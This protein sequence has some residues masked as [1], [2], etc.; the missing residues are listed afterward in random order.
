MY[1]CVKHSKSLLFYNTVKSRKTASFRQRHYFI[2]PPA[3]GMR[4][5]TQR[6]EAAGEFF[7]RV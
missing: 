5:G 7:R 6:G 2:V 3:C 1:P 4:G